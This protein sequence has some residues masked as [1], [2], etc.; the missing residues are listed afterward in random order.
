MDYRIL[1]I[2]ELEWQIKE[3]DFKR[4]AKESELR[5]LKEAVA[6]SD[7]PVTNPIR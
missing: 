1:R 3:L 2:A 7:P 6:K 4:D 5:R